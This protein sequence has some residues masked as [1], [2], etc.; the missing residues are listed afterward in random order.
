LNGVEELL[1]PVAKSAYIDME[2]GAV[3]GT[4]QRLNIPIEIGAVIYNPRSDELEIS[5]KKFYFDIDVEKW[6][7][8][9]DKLGRTINV[10][11]RVINLKTPDTPK[12]YDKKFCL[13]P[14]S[15]K[16]ALKISRIIHNNLHGYM[17]NLAKN[18]VRTLI[19]F[20]KERET[21][22]LR[23]AGFN[24]N[25]LVCLDLQKESKESLS[26]KQSMSLDRLSYIIKFQIFNTTIHSE[27]YTYTIPEKY[28]YLIKPHKAI[29]DTARMFLLSK[30]LYHHT[31]TLKEKIESYLALCEKE[32]IASK[33]NQTLKDLK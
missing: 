31:D 7:N 25:N 9:V 4:H 23:R 8:V 21:L 19:F 3:Y 18:N 27:H 16:N 26:L 10:K 1:D 32:A 15:K 22:T 17:Q 6:G 29:G 2:F 14:Q 24:T 13:D 28:Q 20:A 33:K 12:T 5:G 11:A 30:E